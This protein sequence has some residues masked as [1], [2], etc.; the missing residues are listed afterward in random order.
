[1]KPVLY[2]DVDDTLMRFPN[3]PKRYKGLEPFQGLPAPGVEDFLKWAREFCEV[4]WLTMWATRGTMHPDLEEKLARWLK[5]P[6]ALIADWHNPIDW[7]DT[8][9]SLKTSGINWDE[10]EAGRPWFWIEDEHLM[11]GEIQILKERKVLRH[12]HECNVS[13]NPNALQ[14]VWRRLLTRKATQHLWT[15][16]AIENS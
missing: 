9:G 13:R 12:Y 5:V 6:Q 3:N 14:K 1:M 15:P 10:H 2:L 7:W 11:P 8:P 16:H 4:R